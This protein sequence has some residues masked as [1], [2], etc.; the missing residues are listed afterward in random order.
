MPWHNWMY[1]KWSRRR[2]PDG[3]YQQVPV[4]GSHPGGAGGGAEVESAPGHCDPVRGVR[5][6]MTLQKKGEKK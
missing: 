6:D 3:E 4:R 2:V 1:R 5:R